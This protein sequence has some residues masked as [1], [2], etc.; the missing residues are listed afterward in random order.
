MAAHLREI[1]REEALLGPYSPQP[2][3]D[4]ARDEDLLE[5][6]ADL[7]NDRQALILGTRYAS[8]PGRPKLPMP[9]RYRDQASLNWSS[10]PT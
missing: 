8:C 2:F 5:L 3:L 6:A 9:A 10:M 1:L 4:L 7:W